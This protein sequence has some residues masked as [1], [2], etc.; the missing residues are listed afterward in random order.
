MKK[1]IRLAIFVASLTVTGAVS[2]Q[3][4]LVDEAA[5][6]VIAKYQAATCEQLKANKSEPPSEK[7]KIAL[8]LLRDDP[9]ARVALL[10]KIAGPVMNKMFECN[11]IP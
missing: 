5:D 11:L 8:D 6:R 4:R 1:S 10:D 3:N 2:A 7:E 9:K